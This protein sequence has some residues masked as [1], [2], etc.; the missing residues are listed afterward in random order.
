M[1]NKASLF[2][3]QGA[4][5]AFH[6]LV[7]AETQGLPPDLIDIQNEILVDTVVGDVLVHLL[8]GGL[9]S[10]IGPLLK[11]NKQFQI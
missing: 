10:T 2:S 9:Q 7:L 8:A 11:A 6:E 3:H 1:K 4:L 5:R